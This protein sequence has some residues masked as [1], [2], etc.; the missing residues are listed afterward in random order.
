MRSELHDPNDDKS[1]SLADAPVTPYMRQAIASP[2]RAAYVLSM[3]TDPTKLGQYDPDNCLDPPDAQWKKDFQ[4]ILDA[5]LEAGAVL[6]GRREDG[7]MVRRDKHRE[8]VVTKEQVIADY[9]KAYREWE[10]R[11]RA[12]FGDGGS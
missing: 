5:K 2:G 4:A 11:E 6:S 10:A 9:R 3:D 1:P 12:R 8:W 7:A